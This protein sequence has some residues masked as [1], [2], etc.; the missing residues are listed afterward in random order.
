MG[1]DVQKPDLA[2]SWW[3]TSVGHS[4]VATPNL[5]TELQCDLVSPVWGVLPKALGAGSP[6]DRCTPYSQQQIYTANR[7]EQPVCITDEGNT[8]RAIHPRNTIWP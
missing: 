6:A 3:D 5:N 4:R 1:E 2:R 7:R 8:T